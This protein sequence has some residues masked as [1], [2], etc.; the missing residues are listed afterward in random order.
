VELNESVKVILE[1]R[2]VTK[3][4]EEVKFKPKEYDL[5]QFLESVM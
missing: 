1:S 3:D 2:L 4:G 5:L